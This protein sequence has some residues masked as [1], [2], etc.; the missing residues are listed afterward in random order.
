MA[1]WPLF[2][3]SS[4]CGFPPG[5]AALRTLPGPSGL[6]VSKNCFTPRG[7][8]TQAQHCTVHRQPR[9]RRG[10]LSILLLGSFS[11]P[12]TTASSSTRRGGEDMEPASIAAIS[13][14]CLSGLEALMAR[15][16]RDSVPQ[17]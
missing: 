6:S 3:D 4:V 15:T 11:V 1:K 16:G 8:A 7:V 2:N 13:A 9:L 12:G 10:S 5:L 17:L 14:N